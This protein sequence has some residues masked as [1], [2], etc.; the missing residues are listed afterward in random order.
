MGTRLQV[1]R[2]MRPSINGVAPIGAAVLILSS[3]L[4]DCRR[5]RE[6]GARPI[7]RQASRYRRAHP[8][9]LRHIAPRGWLQFQPRTGGRPTASKQN[10]PFRLAHGARYCL[11]K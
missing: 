9:A 2:A 6:V 11:E 3:L 4:T 10:S 7:P 1:V 8:P 5:V